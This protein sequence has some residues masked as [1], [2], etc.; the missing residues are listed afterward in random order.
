[1]GMC[2][3]NFAMLVL[4]NGGLP[5]G[6]FGPPA[7][8]FAVLGAG[9]IFGELY[10]VQ[11]WRLVSANFVHLSFLHLGLNMYALLSFGRAFEERFDGP[12]LVVTY[13]VT[14]VCGF[15][16]SGW[17]YGFSPQTA[18]ASASLFGLIGV[19]IAY[20]AARKDPNVKDIFFQYLFMAV[21]LAI[22]LPVNNFAHLGGF[23]AG[24]PV[25]VLFSRERA[26]PGRQRAYRIAA[27]LGSAIAILSIALC[28]L[29]LLAFRQQT[30]S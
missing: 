29:S 16:M 24:L 28:L 4:M 22:I 23:L 19:E 13:L 30:G 8:R 18:G 1:M 7:D 15:A 21:A 12:R 2:V 20:L 14:G 25:G 10:L 26:T 11:P 6:L 5:L 17:M 27:L 3:V 9:G